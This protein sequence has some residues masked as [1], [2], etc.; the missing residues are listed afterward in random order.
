MCSSSALSVSVSVNSSAPSWRPQS[1]HL[2]VYEVFFFSFHFARV[3]SSPAK[4]VMLHQGFPSGV[5]LKLLG[6]TCCREMNEKFHH[7]SI[8]PPQACCIDRSSLQNKAGMK[9]EIVAVLNAVHDAGGSDR[10]FPWGGL[11]TRAES[12]HEHFKLLVEHLQRVDGF[13]TFFL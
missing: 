2:F 1:C 7:T 6:S 5:W 4:Y 9:W 10:A 11:N 12:F 13:F 8:R 3:S